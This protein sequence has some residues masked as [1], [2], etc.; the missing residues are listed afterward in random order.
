MYINYTRLLEKIN[1]LRFD[2]TSINS[3]L[4]KLR[5]RVSVLEASLKKE[6]E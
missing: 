2:L 1:D 6:Q 4:K 3:E 5:A